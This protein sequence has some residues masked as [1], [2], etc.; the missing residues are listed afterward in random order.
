M[1]YVVINEE[2]SH[3]RD[4]LLYLT[5]IATTA[6]VVAA[7]AAVITMRRTPKRPEPPYEPSIIHVEGVTMHDDVH[8][9]PLH[10]LKDRPRLLG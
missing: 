4:M 10:G 3:G 7:V 5:I 1:S 6:T 2:P 8:D 9:L